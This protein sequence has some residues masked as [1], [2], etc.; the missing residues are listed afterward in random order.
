MVRVAATAELAWDDAP[1][2]SWVCEPGVRRILV[3]A[4]LGARLSWR[5]GAQG[6]DLE[7]AAAQLLTA[8]LDGVRRLSDPVTGGDPV[9]AAHT[10]ADL[11]GWIRH[12]TASDAPAVDRRE[13]LRRWE[14]WASWRSWL[15]QDQPSLALGEW[16][17]GLRRR[18]PPTLE[19][20]AEV[21]LEARGGDDPGSARE[22]WTLVTP[23][24]KASPFDATQ[25]AATSLVGTWPGSPGEGP[26][27]IALQ[28]RRI[29]WGARV[30]VETGP[31][32]APRRVLTFWRLAEASLTGVPGRWQVAWLPRDLAPSPGEPV[33][34]RLESWPR[35]TLSAARLQ[36]L[37][38]L[39]GESRGTRGPPP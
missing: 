13:L 16:D 2:A 30:V 37:Y 33:R 7:V 19:G 25:E 9:V 14:D 36:R 38:V 32:E 5:R 22:N 4:R 8:G 39:A 34:L 35:K 3:P 31:A 28:Y 1:E 27:R 24:A 29:P 11:R 20:A 17:P 26:L 23:A 15:N 12:L 21:A 6:G 18:E 10:W